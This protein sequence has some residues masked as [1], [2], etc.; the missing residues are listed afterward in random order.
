LPT[1]AQWEFAARG[2]NLS[3]GYKYAGSNNLNNIAWFNDNS[4]EQT[5]PVAQKQPNELGL[6]DMSGNV[7][8]WCNDRYGDYSSLPQHNP[9]GPSSGCHRVL[10]GGSWV[11]GTNECQVSFRDMWNHVHGF[12]NHGFRLSLSL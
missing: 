2:G 9:I 10:R 8:E 3:Q 12:E 1:E 11:H 6:Y 4:N 5:H 7:Q